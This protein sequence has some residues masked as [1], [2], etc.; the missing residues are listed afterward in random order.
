M[1]S[2]HLSLLRSEIGLRFCETWNLTN[3]QLSLEEKLSYVNQLP[4]NFHP[5]TTAFVASASA[6]PIAIGSATT[7]NLGGA[8]IRLK[9]TPSQKYHPYVM[10]DFKGEFGSS[11]QSYFVG[12]ELGKDF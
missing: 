8:E 7:A 9:Y 11:Y 5:A 10:L 6:F 2:Q 4:F 12:L 1:K 3:G